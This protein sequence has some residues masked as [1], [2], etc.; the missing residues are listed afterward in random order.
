MKAAAVDIGS[1]SVRLLVSDG[2]KDLL[3][4]STVTGLGRGV[5]ET[6][7]LGDAEMAVTMEVLAGFRRRVEDLGV[8]RV[9]AVATAASRVAANTEGFMDRAEKALGSR[10]RVIS[11][12]TEATLSF[13]GATAHL[14]GQ[15][16]V[17]DIGGASTEFISRPDAGRSLDVGS[18]RL[19]D[20]FLAARP[21]AAA[22]L[23]EARRH[24]TEV[25]SEIDTSDLAVL[26]VAG[27]WTSLAG[28]LT[29]SADPVVIHNSTVT[30]ADLDGL[31]DRL[32]A[33]SIEETA[34][35]PGLD[36]AR[37]PVI[38]GGAVVA[39]ACLEILDV[40]S[41]QVSVHDLLD[42]LIAEMFRNA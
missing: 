17:V 23:E 14:P 19:T 33:T 30:R 31:V 7:R 10:P 34:I 4:L 8:E 6:G 13:L 32:S 16:M 15:W 5:A 26:G 9:A 25:M 37:A 38:L 11:G 41:A 36:P 35:L 12:I 29:R 21:V 18:V 28:L 2:G 3:R 39:N 1:N 40:P 24:C 27:T 42:G 20:R 22:S